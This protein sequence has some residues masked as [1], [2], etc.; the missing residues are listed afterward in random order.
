MAKR[1]EIEDT[2]QTAE[3]IAL[4]AKKL[5][6]GGPWGQLTFP[7]GASATDLIEFLNDN[8]GAC[9]A[10]VEWVL[11]HVCDSDGNELEDEDEDE[12]ILELCENIQELGKSLG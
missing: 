6:Y 8:P 9:A 5:G 7:N 12:G 4:M 3:G 2:R 10:I 11:E 1:S